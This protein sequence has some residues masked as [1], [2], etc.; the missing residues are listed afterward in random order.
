VKAK[1]SFTGRV[2]IIPPTELVDCSYLAYKEERRVL[3]HSVRTVL[4]IARGQ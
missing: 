2:P 1:K 4:S 3:S